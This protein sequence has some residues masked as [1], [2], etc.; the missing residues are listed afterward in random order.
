MAKKM[1]GRWERD[2]I[3][4]TSIYYCRECD[5]CGDKIYLSEYQAQQFVNNVWLHHETIWTIIKRKLPKVKVEW[6]RGD[7]KVLTRVLE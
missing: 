3:Y 5:T 4:R 2:P 6:G 7:E 1:I